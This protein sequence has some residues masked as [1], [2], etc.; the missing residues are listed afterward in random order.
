MKKLL[1]S[2]LAVCCCQFS[3]GQS[4]FSDDFEGYATGD[5]I[6]T[7]SSGWTTWSGATGNSEDV[8]TTTEQS[9]SGQ[10][11]IKFVG[12]G[13]GGPQD[14]IS[15]FGGEK[16][17][18]GFLSTSLNMYVPTGKVGYFNI[19]GEVTVG[20]TWSI[21]VF[22]QNGNIEVT[23][24][25]SVIVLTT[26]IN[27]DEWF[28][29]GFDINFD[30]NSWKLVV[31]GSCV[32]VYANPS[33]S[34]A[35]IDLFPVANGE[36]FVDDY[37]YSYQPEAPNPA[38]DAGLSGVNLGTRGIQ[39][40]QK[41]VSGSVVNFG[42]DAITSFEVEVNNNGESTTSAFDNLNLATG[43]SI[44]FA[45]DEKILVGGGTNSV[46]VRLSKINGQ[47]GDED[48]CNN[49]ATSIFEGVVPADSKKVIMEESTG[50]WCGFC[51]RGAVGMERLLYQYPDHFIGIAVHGGSANEPML[52]LEY[53]RGLD[54]DGYPNAKVDRTVDIDPGSGEGPFYDRIIAPPVA[55]L[56][57][58]AE[59]DETSRELNVSLGVNALQAIEA[60]H[61]VNIVITEDGVHSDDPAYAQRNYFSGGTTD[62]IDLAGR[63]YKDLPDPVPASEMV[64]DHVA[65]ASL[66]N[67]DGQPFAGSDLSV[68][69]SRTVNFNYTIPEEYNSETMHIIAIMLAPDGTVNN[70]NSVTI[71]EAVANGFVTSTEY[72]YELTS[73][74]NVFPNPV[75]DIATV[76]VLIEELNRVTV[77][78]MDVTGAI[79][80]TEDFGTLSGV[81]KLSIDTQDLPKGFYTLKINAGNK[82]TTS[83]IIKQ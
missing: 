17:T 29:V 64:Y 83:K 2:I 5:F 11:S 76:E 28:N 82:Y 60:G 36:F 81:Q 54:P 23:D 72:D 75:R 10:H 40:A 13:Q 65:R 69:E 63:N 7:N 1:L 31:N 21:N 24:G 4:S 70:G 50:T 6:G 19:Q 15:Y 79:I 8:R 33:N 20:Q 52:L 9:A 62:L 30:I 59:Y 55:N 35:S 49:L 67:Y 46:T 45:L 32:G 68:G 41:D 39:G 3:Y 57:L 22:V 61:T 80:K 16:L 71:A 74:T 73:L 27:H 47:E 43:E 66:G 44:D 18:T 51:P 26:P 12:V 48:D 56:D 58:G 53:D 37:Q 38:L 42:T 34:A 14:V 25:A 77:N 78:V